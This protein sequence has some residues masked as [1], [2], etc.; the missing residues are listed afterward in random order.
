MR[1]ASFSLHWSLFQTTSHDTNPAFIHICNLY[2]NNAIK[3]MVEVLCD[4]DKT[5]AS[6]L[7]D[8]YVWYQL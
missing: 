3:P 7:D 8:I 6:D 1:K 5:G 4:D 2:N